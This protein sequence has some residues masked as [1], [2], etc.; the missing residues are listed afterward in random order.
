MFKKILVPYDGSEHSVKA[1]DTAMEI[2]E[3]LN[4]KI[5]LIHVYS[6]DMPVLMYVPTDLEPSVGEY[7]LSQE[8]FSKIAEASQRAAA[9]ILA[10]GE[11]KVRAKGIAVETLL[12][13]GHIVQEILEA[14]K[15][16][17]FDLIVIGAKGV[18]KIR[19]MLLG[20]VSEKVIRNAQCPV[21]VVK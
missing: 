7:L 11:K 6:G 8:D 14:V 21:L 3:K 2:A 9:S 20:S 13:K 18:S 16:G 15:N 12:K 19:E 5:T 4:G 10:K 1:L 17:K